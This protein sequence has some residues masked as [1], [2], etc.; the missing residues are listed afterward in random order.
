PGF[1]GLQQL[2]HFAL[3]Q[4]AS[5]FGHLVFLQKYCRAVTPHPGIIHVCVVGLKPASTVGMTHEH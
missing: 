3:C 4:V 2:L 1:C 5:L